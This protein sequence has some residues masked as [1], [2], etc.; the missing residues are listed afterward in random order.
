MYKFFLFYQKN[1]YIFDVWQVILGDNFCQ[2]W[3]F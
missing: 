3:I 1:L 2:F